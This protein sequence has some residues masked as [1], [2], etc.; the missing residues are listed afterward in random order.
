MASERHMHVEFIPGNYE[1][2]PDF[3]Y[4]VLVIQVGD[5]MKR[6]PSMVSVR[7]VSAEIWEGLNATTFGFPGKEASAIEALPAIKGEESVNRISLAGYD[8]SVSVQVVAEAN[9]L[10]YHHVYLDW[11]TSTSS[12]QTSAAEAL[13]SPPPSGDNDRETHHTYSHDDQRALP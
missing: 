4:F 5:D 3:K 13:S 10:P 8:I 2:N 1:S 9:E 11:K 12:H 7:I 6:D